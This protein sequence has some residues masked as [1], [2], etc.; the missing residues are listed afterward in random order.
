MASAAAEYEAVVNAPVV[1]T[2][3]WVAGAGGTVAT[4][5]VGNSRP[6][7]VSAIL[8]RISS[9]EDRSSGRDP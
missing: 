6:A 7:E 1:I 3:N 2:P 4:W 8:G 5:L 9:G